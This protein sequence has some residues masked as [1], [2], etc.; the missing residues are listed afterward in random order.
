MHAN[1]YNTD[2]NKVAFFTDCFSPK[3]IK[4]V[5]SARFTIERATSAINLSATLHNYRQI[6]NYS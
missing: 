6:F 2:P 1:K 5:F 3:I 4:N